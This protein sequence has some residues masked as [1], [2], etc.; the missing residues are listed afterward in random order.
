MKEL[1][2]LIRDLREDHDL[3]QGDVAAYLH[4]SQQVYSK[5]ERGQREI[6]AWVVGA[7]SEYYQVSADYLLGVSMYYP[8]NTDLSR[9]YLNRITFRE[10]IYDMQELPHKNREKLIRYIGYL[11]AVSCRESG[12]IKRKGQGD[13]TKKP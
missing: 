10:V 9:P 12:R 5:F 4:V 2:E 3:K 7:L 6:P 11:K 1:R 13:K 8:G